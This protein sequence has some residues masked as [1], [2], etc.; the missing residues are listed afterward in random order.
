MR[1]LILFIVVL[2]F[3]SLAYSQANQDVVYLKNGTIIKGTITEQVPNEQLKIRTIEG[4]FYTCKFTE[5]EKITQEANEVN[6]EEYGGKLSYGIAL[7]GGGLFGV[8]FRFYPS[9]LFALEIG[10]YYRPM[11][12]L[13]DG[14]TNSGLMIAGGLN[15]FLDKAYNHEKG[16]IK[17]DGI[18]LKAGYS[19]AEYPESIFSAGWAH[20]SF[21]KKNK[22]RSFIFELG[23]GI[24]KLNTNADFY[25]ANEKKTMPLIYWKCNW[26]WYAK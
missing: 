3:S 22:N 8:P 21:K 12:R 5:I 24:A 6:L 13:D 20:E 16:K 17:L 1:K 15:I 18:S 9:P 19:F 10:A 11:L 25:Y 7:G 14:G 2:L 26:N 23:M 4:L